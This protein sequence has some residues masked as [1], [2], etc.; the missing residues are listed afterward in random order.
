M[1]N[2]T[3][4]AAKVLT[5]ITAERGVRRIIITF[6]SEAPLQQSFIDTQGAL[7]QQELN[8]DAQLYGNPVTETKISVEQVEQ[9]T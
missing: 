6:E 7:L 5:R 4:E 8:V 1:N 9:D 3:Q 2:S